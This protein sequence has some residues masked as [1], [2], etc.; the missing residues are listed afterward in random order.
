MKNT[1]LLAFAFL[2]VLEGFSQQSVVDLPAPDSEGWISLWRGDNPED[3]YTFYSGNGPLKD[4]AQNFPDNTFR[5]EG[6]VIKVTG[7]PTGH[8]IHKQSFSHYRISYQMRF[9]GNLGN[10]GMLLHIQEDDPAM[11]GQF[12]RSLESQGDPNQGLGQLWCIGDVWVSVRVV[13]NNTIRWDPNGELITYGARTTNNRVIEGKDGWAQP[14]PPQLQTGEWI[15]QE[16]EVHGND[17]IMHYVEGDLVIKYYEPRVAPANAPDNVQKYLEAGQLAWQ[18]EGTAVEYQNIKIKL[19]PEDPL[20]SS[21]YNTEGCTDTT[22]LNYN[23]EA[24]SSCEDCCVYAC[25][26]KQEYID[27]DA[28]CEEA[29]YREEACVTLGIQE[30]FGKKPIELNNSNLK[31][32]L[33]GSYQL[34]V[35]D[36][37]GSVLISQ[38]HKSATEISLAQ[39]NKGIYIVQLH[40]GG[41]TFT[42]QINLF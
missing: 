38:K 41:K 11:W 9:P 7:S 42:K 18:S 36:L 10:C 2:F 28:S 12:P 25:C 27:Y 20:Y 3:F 15:T 22:A 33:S 26:N 16:A 4:H 6:D 8:L 40:Q 21:L 5:F 19:L 14:K 30:I 24:I 13:N 17:S 32:N 31:I 34:D 1:Y 39:L 23:A 29:N 35:K 37:S